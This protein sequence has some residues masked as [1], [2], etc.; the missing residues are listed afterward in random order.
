MLVV[1]EVIRALDQP[2]GK[3]RDDNDRLRRLRHQRR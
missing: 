1:D 3:V 2:R